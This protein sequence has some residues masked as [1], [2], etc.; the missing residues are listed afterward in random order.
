MSRR[1][2]NRRKRRV[3]ARPPQLSVAQILAWADAFRARAGQW[4]LNSFGRIPGALGETWRRVD[5]ALRL[6]LR[7][8]PGGSSLAQLLHEQRGVRNLGALPR[9]TE[10][11]ILAWADAHHRRTGRWPNLDAGPVVEAPGETWKAIDSAM[12]LGA[13]GFPGGSSLTSLLAERRAVRNRS[14]QP[15]LPVADILAWADAHRRRT[16]QWPKCYSGAVA[17]APEETWMGIDKALKRGTRGLPG[18][19]SLAHLLAEHRGIRHQPSLP[20]LDHEMILAWADAHHARTGRWPAGTFGRIADAPAETWSGVDKALR[21]GIR[22]LPGGSSVIRLLAEHRG[23]RNSRHL[24]RLTAGQI[25]AWVDAH[26]RRTGRWPTSE[27]GP[28]LDA[29]GET[30]LAVHQALKRGRRGRPGGTA[31]CEFIR[32]NRPPAARPS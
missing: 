29:P 26:R 30:W 22:G 17:A 6:G 13:R 20:H 31:L 27:S 32:K 2:K 24:P 25:L 10:E 3:G 19:S 7:G 12:R 23:V 18:G 4:P 11:Q 15:A 8:L 5:S 1:R 14:W 9:L 28:V 21:I 16:G